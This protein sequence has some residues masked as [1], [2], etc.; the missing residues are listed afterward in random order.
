MEKITAKC[1]C[2]NQRLVRLRRKPRKGEAISGIAQPVP[3]EAKESRLARLLVC[4]GFASQPPVRLPAM[5]IPVIIFTFLFSTASAGNRLNIVVTIAPQAEFV[6][7]V[8]GEYVNVSV[9]IPAVGNPH[10]Y[11][12]TPSQLRGVRDADLY[13]KLGSGIEFELM[14]MDKIASINKGL[15]IIDNSAGITLIESEEEESGHTKDPHIWLSPKNTVIMIGG[16]K[17]AL[18]GRDPEHADVYRKNAG[19]YINELNSL[20]REIREKLRDKKKRVFMV[21]HPAWVYFARDYG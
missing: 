2:A 21:F 14:W 20:D 6:E 17:D 11:E 19:A 4:F 16:I 9:M 12:P 3:S 8:G 10:T 7:K 13:F 18:I 1:H 15:T 5:T